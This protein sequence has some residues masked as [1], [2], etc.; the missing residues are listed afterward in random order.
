MS[1]DLFGGSTKAEQNTE[2]RNV[3]IQGAG[4]TVLG[5]G[6][7]GRNSNQ[8][9]DIEVTDFGAIETLQE[10]GR[11]A[12]IGSQAT[13]INALD[14][15]RDNQRETN[16]TLEVLGY[17]AGEVALAA[18]PTNAGDITRAVSTSFL[19]VAVGIGAIVLLLQ[20]MKKKR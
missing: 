3:G 13:A 14:V 5:L 19:K 7:Q 16:E 10:L 12:I 11:E 1:F 6:N 20:I 15:L 9:V 2:N 17:Q 18:T 4:N 8:Y